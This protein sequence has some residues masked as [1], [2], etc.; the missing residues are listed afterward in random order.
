MWS[1]AQIDRGRLGTA[2]AAP[3]P[4]YDICKLLIPDPAKQ[5]A[6]RRYDGT[7]PAGLAAHFDVAV[8]PVG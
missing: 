5:E 7:T 1:G 4:G 3:K 8:R 2:S 6:D